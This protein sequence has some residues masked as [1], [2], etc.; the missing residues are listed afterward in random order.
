MKVLSLPVQF[1]TL[2]CILL[3]IGS[4]MSFRHRHRHLPRPRPHHRPW[5]RG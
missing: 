1:L 2:V 5:P 4:T 3:S